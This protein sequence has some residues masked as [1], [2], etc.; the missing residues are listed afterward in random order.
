M[1]DC[2]PIATFGQLHHPTGALHLEVSLTTSARALPYS[3]RPENTGE[4]DQDIP[5]EKFKS[6]STLIG[7]NSSPKTGTAGPAVANPVLPPELRDERSQ[8]LQLQLL[9][10]EAVRP[11]GLDPLVPVAKFVLDNRQ[12]WR[13]LE[14][15][16]PINPPIDA[17]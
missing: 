12:Q 14:G 6:S 17:T 5:Q 11:E 3:L 4:L 16:L 7:L 10:L 1:Q 9:T 15:L 2:R 8:F 13:D